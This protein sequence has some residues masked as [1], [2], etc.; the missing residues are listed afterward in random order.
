MSF[1][2]LPGAGWYPSNGTSES[3]PL[4]AGVVAVA[5]QKAGHPLGLLNPRLY[6]LAAEHAPGIVP[7][8]VGTTT[9]HFRQDNVN[10]TVDGW[11]ATKGYNLA[12]GLGTVNGAALVDELAARGRS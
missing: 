4:F 1:P 6:Q 12:V 8:T 9:V 10:V 7:V 5:D 11:A 2:G 3:G